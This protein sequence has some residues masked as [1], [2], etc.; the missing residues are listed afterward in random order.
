LTIKLSKDEV[1]RLALDEDR[2]PELMAK[3]QV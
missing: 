3:F 1:E 2:P